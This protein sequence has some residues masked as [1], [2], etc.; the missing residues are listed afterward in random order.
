MEN[1][2][3]RLGYRGRSSTSTVIQLANSETCR[4]TLSVRFWSDG[5]NDEQL[6]AIRS[7]CNR[8][9]ENPMLVDHCEIR[10][11]SIR[12]AVDL[13]TDDPAPLWDTIWNRWYNDDN[14]GE[15]VRSLRSSAYWHG[16]DCHLD[17]LWVY[18][19]YKT[20]QNQRDGLHNRLQCSGCERYFWIGHAKRPWN[21]P[22]CDGPLTHAKPADLK[23]RER[24]DEPSRDHKRPTTRVLKSSVI[25]RRP[26]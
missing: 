19:T 9:A 25:W 22:Y 11:D 24:R 21:C 10:H 1:Q 26:G 17:A 2:L 20:S 13:S 7:M 14:F 16:E 5:F 15:W 12:F 18:R 23:L 6:L 4:N 8:L 3:P